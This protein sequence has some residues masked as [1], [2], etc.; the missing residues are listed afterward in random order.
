MITICGNA[1]V[2]ADIFLPNLSA[3]HPNKNVPIIA[4]IHSVAPIHDV[5]SFDTGPDSSGV[6]FDCK[7][8]RN[9]DVQPTAVPCDRDIKFTGKNR[10]CLVFKI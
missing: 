2:H 1:T 10:N 6:S 4:P 9:G 8:G 5:S 3:I 7:I